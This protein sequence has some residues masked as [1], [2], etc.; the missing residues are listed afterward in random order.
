MCVNLY[1]TFVSRKVL[2]AQ[3]QRQPFIDDNVLLSRYHPL[4]GFVVNL[5]AGPILIVTPN[6]SRQEIVPSEPYYTERQ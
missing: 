6:M 3:P 4:T 5:V 2:L 1:L